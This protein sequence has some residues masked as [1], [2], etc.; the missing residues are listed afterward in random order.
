MRRYLSA[1]LIPCFLMQIFGCYSI[2]EISLKELADQEEPIIITADSTVYYLKKRIRKQEMINHPGVYY[3]DDWEIN[4][5]TGI[6]YLQTQKVH[7]EIR[8]GLEKFILTKD[9]TNINFN[10][11]FAVSVD[12]V[13][14]GKTIL[15]IGSILV[16][17]AGL[18]LMIIGFY[19]VR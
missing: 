11:I 19:G 2:E 17:C 9:T 13:S 15:L 18:L 5:N 14:T 7:M 6:V 8:R 3:S 16:G 1:I 4:P 12:K 10:E